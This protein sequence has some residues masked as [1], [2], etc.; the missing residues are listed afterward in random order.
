MAVTASRAA[1]DITVFMGPPGVILTLL[2]FSQRRKARKGKQENYA[3]VGGLVFV[4]W[5]V[6]L[7]VAVGACGATRVEYAGGTPAELRE[8]VRGAIDV[9]DQGYLAFYAGKTQVRVPYGRVNLLEYGQQVDRRLAL[10]MVISPVF[11]LG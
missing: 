7:M 8:G 9:S 1:K 5:V 10:A 6:Y 4:R 3:W 11:L 2:G